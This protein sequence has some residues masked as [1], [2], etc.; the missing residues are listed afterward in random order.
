M[1]QF[2]WL[3]QLF[4]EKYARG[5]ERSVDDVYEEEMGRLYTDAMWDDFGRK[6]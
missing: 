3:I 4:Q 1:K 2:Q 5:H 6:V